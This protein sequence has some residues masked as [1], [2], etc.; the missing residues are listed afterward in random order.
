MTSEYIKRDK[1]LFEKASAL[2][3]GE[4]GGLTGVVV[5]LDISGR[6]LRKV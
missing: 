3:I 4:L 6:G 2:L 1:N 5:N